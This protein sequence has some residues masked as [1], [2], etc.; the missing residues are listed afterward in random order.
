[1]NSA[2]SHSLSNYPNQILIENPGIATYVVGDLAPNTY[3][4]VATAIN[5]QGIES[6]FSN[7]ARK[8]VL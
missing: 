3:N 7:V 5:M 1:M 6:E 2:F 4:F 8:V